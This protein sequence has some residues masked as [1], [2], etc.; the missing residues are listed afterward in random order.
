M[1]NFPEYVAFTLDRLEKSGYSAYLVGG[2]VRDYIMGIEPHDFDITTNALPDEIENC[3]SDIK[4]LDIGK[5]HGTI[6]LVFKNANVEVT[7]YRIDGEYKDSRHP[8]SVIFTDR[9]EADLARRDFSVN[10]IAFS[11]KS[12]FVDPFCGREDIENKIIRC[13]GMPGIRFDEDA[14]RIMRGLRFAS[15]FGFEIDDKTSAAIHNKKD[16]LLNIAMERINSEFESLL[17]EPFCSQIISEYLDVFKVFIPWIDD[18]NITALCRASQFNLVVALCVLF[19]ESDDLVFLRDELKRL[20]IDNVTL[21]KIV[22]VMSLVSEYEG[23]YGNIDIR[24]AVSAVG[25]DS[26]ENLYRVLY[27]FTGNDVYLDAVSKICVFNDTGVCMSLKQLDI[28]GNEIIENYNIEPSKIGKILSLL[29]CDVIEEKIPNKKPF[30]L[31][32]VKNY[33]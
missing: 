17:Q 18:V 29:L 1:L 6:T 31:E 19:S 7:T 5:K 28:K 16:L 4:T 25:Q 13:V 33:V 8:E 22:S 23:K 10:A 2:C 12:G 3:F 27:C 30:L 11:P 14:L 9:I 32:R 24:K 21:K 20:K 15:R 26:A